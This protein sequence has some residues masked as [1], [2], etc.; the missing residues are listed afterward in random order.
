MQRPVGPA[1]Y[2]TF[3]LG[4]LERSGEIELLS[5]VEAGR[6]DVVLCLDGRCRVAR[7]RRT[8]TAVLD[9][10]HLFERGGYG[11]R[12]WLEQ[13]WRVA[14]AVRRSDHLLAPSE[15]VRFGLERYL[16]VPADRI[17]VL[18]PTPGPGFR[19]PPRAEV[20]A[21]RA[22]LGLPA[23]YFLFVGTRS[24]R[25]NLG[26]LAEAW[27]A[28]AARLPDPPGLV[29]AGPGGGGVPGALDLGYVRAERLPALIA[30]ALALVNPSLYEGSA[31][32]VQEAM[33][34]GTPPL[35][36]GTGAMPHAV[37]MAGLILD[38]HDV[39]EWARALEVVARD[40]E[41]RSR[42]SV[43]GLRAAVELRASGPEPGRAAAAIAG[44]AGAVR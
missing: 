15:A 36:A 5:G 14:S 42:L 37:A 44:V 33:A 27:S 31:L 6:A 3:A 12:E 18:A 9:L 2:A 43:A 16:R 8:V 24:R 39:A 13:N 20:D 17:T 32:G 35:V 1:V 19:R 21:V 25:K 4:L 22:A 41:L 26:L 10:G 34:C 28:A 30:G 40:G 7:A 23:A 38:P 29:L 11:R